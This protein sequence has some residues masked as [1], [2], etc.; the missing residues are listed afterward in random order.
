VE[1]ALQAVVYIGTG[2]AALAYLRAAAARRGVTLADIGLTARGTLVGNI[3]YG[4]AGYCAILP[5]LLALR[6]LAQLLFRHLPNTAPNPIMPLIVAERDLA[7]RLVIFVLVALAAPFFEELFF[8]GAL[9]AGLRSRWGWVASSIVSALLFA[10]VHP[11]QDWLPIV[12]LGL[13]FAAMREMRQSL[14]PS[15]TAH[16]LQNS[17]TFFSLSM[18]F[19]SG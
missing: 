14:V 12:G 8:R 3:G 9:F 16:L 6:A 1:L 17:I 18:L 19:Q 5:L 13:G 2:L 15:I 7:W 10:V 11:P 4:I